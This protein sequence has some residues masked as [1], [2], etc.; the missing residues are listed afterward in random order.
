M[1]S[2]LEDKDAIRELMARYCFHID[3]AEFEEWLQ[4]FTE[5]GVFEVVN[6]GRFAGREQLRQFLGSIPLTDGLPMMKHCVMNEIVE[7]TGD[8]AAARAYIVVVHGGEHVSVRVAG[9]YEDRLR[10]VNGRW[11]FAE[12]KAYLDFMSR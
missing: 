10:R 5:D 12:R 6:L 9:R 7:V 4:L 2:P 1:A 8:T 3:A 11:L